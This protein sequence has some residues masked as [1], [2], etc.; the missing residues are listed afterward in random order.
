MEETAGHLLRLWEVVQSLRRCPP[1]SSILYAHG[2]Q[3]FASPVGRSVPESL[4]A[5][6]G[7]IPIL[8]PLL[9]ELSMIVTL[10]KAALSAVTLLLTR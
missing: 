5:F 6:E 1:V 4:I 7:T 3:P 9:L 2:M 10:S 8:S